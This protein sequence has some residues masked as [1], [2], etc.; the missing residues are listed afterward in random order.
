MQR[1][2]ADYFE[3]AVELAKNS[4]CAMKHGAVMVIG[5]RVISFGFNSFKAEKNPY[6][7]K[8]V[9]AEGRCC[10][11]NRRKIPRY[12]Q[13]PCFEQG[14]GV[15][16]TTGSRNRWIGYGK[17]TTMHALCAATS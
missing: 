10:Y 5:G 16:S 9:H 3:Q 4:P 15:R 8:T 1:S 7:G 14:Q 6:Y 2:I 13:K 12:R 11:K 17:L